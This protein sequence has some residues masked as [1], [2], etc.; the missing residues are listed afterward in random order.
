MVIGQAWSWVDGASSV[1]AT[2]LCVQDRVRVCVSGQGWAVNR[3]W[4]QPTGHAWGQRAVRGAGGLSSALGDALSRGLGRQVLG[5][6]AGPWPQH[7]AW[8]HRPEVRARRRGGEGS[9]LLVS[10]KSTGPRR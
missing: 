3:G 1:S 4:R 5:R 6:A 8:S 10:G 9:W 2:A 7:T